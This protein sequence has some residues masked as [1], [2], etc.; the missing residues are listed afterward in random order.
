MKKLL[1]VMIAVLFCIGLITPVKADET[2]FVI[3]EYGL[4]TLD[5]YNSLYAQAQQIYDEYEIG[6]YIVITNDQYGY[7]ESSYANN[8]YIRYGLGYGEGNSGILLA[9]AMEE[10][11]VDITSYGAA[12]ET[13]STSVIDSILDDVYEYLYDGDWSGACEEFVSLSESYI[14]N[15]DYTYH[16]IEYNDPEITVY[17]SKED[18]QSQWLSTLPIIA[19]VSL[20]LGTLQMFIRK[21]KLKTTHR[22]ATAGGYVATPHINLT[23]RGDY[24]INKTRHVQHVQRNQGGGPGGGGGGGYHSSGFSGSS[25][26]RHF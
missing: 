20:L 23:T 15:T 25:G 14:V 1:T 26:G 17:V 11:Y 13:F 7:S 8:M 18:R 21:R 2:S 9:I 5:E 22:A 10:R 24:F 3:D 12:G 4:L 6:V 19:L 16:D